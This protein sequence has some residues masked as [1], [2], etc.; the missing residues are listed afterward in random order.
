[1]SSKTAYFTAKTA[2]VGIIA[3]TLVTI[4]LL[5]EG[6]EYGQSS[7]HT[8]STGSETI[9][10]SDNSETAISRKKWSKSRLSGSQLEDQVV[11]GSS[12]IAIGDNSSLGGSSRVGYQIRG[13]MLKPTV[14]LED[15]DLVLEGKVTARK[16]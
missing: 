11:R 8:T 14:E 9:A 16:R 6:E 1:M 5:G 2:I 13:V 10:D 4:P 3:L 15:V 12:Y 7:I